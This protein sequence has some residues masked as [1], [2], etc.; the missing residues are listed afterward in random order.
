[1]PDPEEPSEEYKPTQSS[2]TTVRCKCS[3]LQRAADEPDHPIVFDTRMNEFHITY[4]APEHRAYLMINHCPWCGGTAP[5]SKR[6][7]FFMNVTDAESMRL[8]D[9]AAGVRTVTDAIARFGPP[10]SDM[11]DGMTMKSPATD[12]EPSVVTSYRVLRYAGLSDTADVSFT[13]Y[14]PERGLRMSLQGKYVGE[15]NAR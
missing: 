14:G 1:M 2:V 7:T 5:R 10:D 15:P 9:L 13:D 8:R 4:G 12:T 11:P 6:E 3:Y